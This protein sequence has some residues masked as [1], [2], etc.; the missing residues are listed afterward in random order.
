MLQGQSFMDR[1]DEMVAAFIS[2]TAA[3]Y[4]ASLL[5]GGTKSLTVLPWFPKTTFGD[6]T[7][8]QR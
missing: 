3:C 4:Q 6:L 7:L 8:K 2:V 5:V 1:N